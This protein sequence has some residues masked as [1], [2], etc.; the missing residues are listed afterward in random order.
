[1]APTG[2]V[3]CHPLRQLLQIH[4]A[5]EV[6]DGQRRLIAMG[7]NSEKLYIILYIYI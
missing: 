1:L 6:N 3:T 5:L 7:G 4:L 2:A